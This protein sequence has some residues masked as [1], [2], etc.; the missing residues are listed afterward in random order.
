MVQLDEVYDPMIYSSKY[1]DLDRE[2]AKSISKKK[3]KYLLKVR[4]LD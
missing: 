1:F 3:E 2:L 4:I